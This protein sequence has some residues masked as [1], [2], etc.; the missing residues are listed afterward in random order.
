MCLEGLLTAIYAVA[1]DS[2]TIGLVIGIA[3][4][5]TS[6]ILTYN[7]RQNKEK[8]KLVGALTAEIGQMRGIEQCANSMEKRN[9]KPSEG[10]LDPDSLPPGKSIPTVVYESNAGRIGLLDQETQDK[11]V[12]FYSKVIQYK[13]IMS[14]ARSDGGVPDAD[15][16][17]LYNSIEEL[18]ETRK[19][20]IDEEHGDNLE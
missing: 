16:D 19:S 11:Y 7:Y 14:A 6:A 5:F 17:D 4:T 8:E 2:T 15:L 10:G 20:L 9:S 1:T 18:S 13:S 12:E 3:T